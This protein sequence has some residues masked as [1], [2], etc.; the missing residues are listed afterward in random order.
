MINNGVPLYTSG[1]SVSLTSDHN[2][3]HRGDDVL[4]TCTWNNELYVNKHA[5]WSVQ[6][7]RFV[8][9]SIWLATGNRTLFSETPLH[10][11]I[12][13]LSSGETNFTSKHSIILHNVTERYT[14][15][16]HCTVNVSDNNPHKSNGFGLRVF[17]M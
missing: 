11:S 14:G 8:S 16:Y 10:D 15:D 13:V 1:F 2:A 17:G 5:L 7:Y 9:E 12:E 4:L 6:C 3:A